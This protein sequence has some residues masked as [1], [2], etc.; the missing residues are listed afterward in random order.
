MA[1]HYNLRS[2]IDLIR[3]RLERRRESLANT[4]EGATPNMVDHPIYPTGF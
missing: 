3:S 4:P 2:H 1:D